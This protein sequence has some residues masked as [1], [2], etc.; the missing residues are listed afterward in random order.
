MLIMNTEHNYS[1]CEWLVLIGTGSCSLPTKNQGNLGKGRLVKTNLPWE[2]I[3]EWP[4]IYWNIFDIDI[5]LLILKFFKFLQSYCLMLKTALLVW[6]PV[7]H[8]PHSI[9]IINICYDVSTFCSENSSHLQ[10][11]KTKITQTSIWLTE[12]NSILI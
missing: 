12:L 10:W 5:I 7:Q 3:S 4:T 6:R 1:W 8:S 11:L 2:N 9:K